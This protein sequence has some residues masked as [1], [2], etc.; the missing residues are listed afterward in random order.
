MGVDLLEENRDRSFFLKD[1]F[2][3]Q[4][5]RERGKEKKKQRKRYFPSTFSSPKCLQQEGRTKARDPIRVFHADTEIQT[6]GP[7]SA[8]F[9]VT[10][11]GS[12]I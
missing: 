8:V 1:L 3:R 2:K 4:S 5:Y 12:W 11:A 10:P 6:R 9:P 7:S